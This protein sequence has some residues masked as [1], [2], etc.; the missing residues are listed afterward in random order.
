M[1]LLI[2]DDRETRI[3]LAE[4]LRDEGYEVVECQDGRQAFDRL[5]DP[6]NV[7]LILLDLRMPVMDGWEFRRL[8]AADPK[9][10]RIPVIVLTADT[11]IEREGIRFD[12]LIRK[13]LDLDDLLSAISA[14]VGPKTDAG[15]GGSAPAPG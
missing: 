5:R 4:I 11:H 13:P 6:Q 8:Q 14:L 12:R 15:P 3:T 10:A 9:L 2:E 7:S 1:I